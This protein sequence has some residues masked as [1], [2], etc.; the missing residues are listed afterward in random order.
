MEECWRG[1]LETGGEA[2]SLMRMKY[3]R[4]VQLIILYIQYFSRNHGE[5]RDAHSSSGEWFRDQEDTACLDKNVSISHQT[6][7]SACHPCL[8]Q[9]WWHQ[10][11]IHWVELSARLAECPPGPKYSLDT[12]NDNPIS[13]F[14]DIKCYWTFQSCPPN[15]NFWFIATDC[16]ILWTVCFVFSFAWLFTYPFYLQNSG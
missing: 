9:L 6:L 13:Q 3:A 8:I 12:A 14:A 16:P 10:A 7:C 5:G 4:K 15:H 1:L 11:L 2:G